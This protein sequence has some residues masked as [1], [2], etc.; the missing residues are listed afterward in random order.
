VVAALKGDQDPIAGRRT[1]PPL[2]R[3]R[4]AELAGTNRRDL[5]RR[6]T[7]QDQTTRSKRAARQHNGR[8][9]DSLAPSFLLLETQKS[10]SDRRDSRGRPDR[11]VHGRNRHG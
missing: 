5:G 6:V 8:D 10:G 2:E 7:M 11:L 9:R 3:S 4:V 1:G